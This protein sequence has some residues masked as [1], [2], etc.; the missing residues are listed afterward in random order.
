MFGIADR[1]RLALRQTA[2]PLLVAA[3][4]MGGIFARE[5]RRETAADLPESSREQLRGFW[6]NG[7]EICRYDLTQSR[8]GSTHP[9]HAELI[10]VTEPFLTEPQVKKEFGDAA[11]IDV[12]RLNAL[13][14]FNTGLYS[15]RTMCSIFTPFEG[16]GR[17]AALKVT[18]SAQDWCGQVFAQANRREPNIEIDLRSYFQAEGDRDYQFEAPNAI[19]E[20]GLWTQLRL[21]PAALPKGAFQALPA[22]LALRL[23]HRPATLY[24]AEGSLTQKGDLAIYRLY[25]PDWGRRLEIRFDVAFPHIIRGWTEDHGKGQPATEARL[26]E[27][28]MNVPYWR[29]NRPEDRSRRQALG[30]AESPR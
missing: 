3:V 21:D 15:Y 23:A 19:M 25:Y 27:R 14:T 22:L 6:F 11:G 30:L 1:L 24:S 28:L 18:L 20:D 4:M 10:F 29:F 5:Q 8:Y 2:L 12:L 7:A 26:A 16:E 17:R 9:G 13:R